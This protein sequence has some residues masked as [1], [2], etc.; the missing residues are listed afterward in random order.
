MIFILSDSQRSARQTD[1]EYPMYWI[2]NIE[3][4]EFKVEGRSDPTITDSAVAIKT[5]N[6]TTNQ[7]SIMPELKNTNILNVTHKIG[8]EI[9]KE[10][11]TNSKK[12]GKEHI[13]TNRLVSKTRTVKNGKITTP[14]INFNAKLRKN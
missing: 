7:E 8:V 14:Q 12:I 6:N 5:S 4:N 2:F 1:T 11:D 13:H 3:K 10:T 9:D